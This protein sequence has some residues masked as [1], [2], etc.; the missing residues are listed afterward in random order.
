MKKISLASNAV[1][2]TGKI[3]NYLKIFSIHLVSSAE[4]LDLTARVKGWI[5]REFEGDVMESESISRS[6]EKRKHFDT[7]SVLD[8]IRNSNFF[9]KFSLQPRPGSFHFP[10]FLFSCQSKDKKNFRQKLWRSFLVFILQ[11]SLKS[12]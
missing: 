6:A 12:A 5:E 9:G 1:K 7:Q 4:A 2:E 8:K 3:S 11:P 10:S